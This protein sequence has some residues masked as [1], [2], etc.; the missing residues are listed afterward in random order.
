ML[1][2]PRLRGATCHAALSLSCRMIVRNL[3]LGKWGFLVTLF[4]GMTKTVGMT[5][6][7]DYLSK[8]T[9][10]SLFTPVTIWLSRS[11]RRPSSTACNVG[12]LLTSL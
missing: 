1:D 7:I 9:W 5:K 3:C 4:L 11:L 10:S 12:W 6:T 8:T 2:E